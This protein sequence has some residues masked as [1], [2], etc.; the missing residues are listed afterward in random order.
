[1]THRTVNFDNGPIE[2]FDTRFAAQ[3]WIKSS[4]GQCR[5]L[6]RGK[7]YFQRKGGFEMTIQLN[8]TECTENAHLLQAANN[9]ADEVEASI[10]QEKVA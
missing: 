1:M 9:L 6:A 7:F 10:S 8:A 3:R 5:V 2:V 4:I